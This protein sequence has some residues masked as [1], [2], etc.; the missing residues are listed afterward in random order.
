[1][2]VLVVD[3]REE[4][5]YLLATLLGGL[6]YEVMLAS[7]G[8]EALERLRAES[9]DLIVSDILMPIMDGYQL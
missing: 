1:M 6:G 5:R 9:F 3:N 2:K 4:D 8:T 7:N